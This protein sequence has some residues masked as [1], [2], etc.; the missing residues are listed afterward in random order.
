MLAGNQ[1]GDDGAASLA[2]SLLMM[3]QLTLLELSG[4]L[5]A[6]ATLVLWAGACNRGLCMDDAACL[7]LGQ[8]R[9]GL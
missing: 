5:R 3:P 4:T 7:R 2:P 8:L 9:T 6:S 1:I